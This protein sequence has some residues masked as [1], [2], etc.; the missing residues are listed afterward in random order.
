MPKP[1]EDMALVSA[2][3]KPDDGPIP[4]E[5]LDDETLKHIGGLITQGKSPKQIGRIIGEPTSKVLTRLHAERH[6]LALLLLP[7][8]SKHMVGTA[9]RSQ[10]ILDAVITEIEDRVAS[11]HL[12]SLKLDDL[13]KLGKAMASLVQPVHQRLALGPLKVNVDSEDKAAV[14]IDTVNLLIQR[15]ADAKEAEEIEL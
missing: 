13:I 5:D 12:K 6:R 7:W 8:A 1:T 4:P 15:I 2:L 9:V 14:S 11:G 3:S 10:T